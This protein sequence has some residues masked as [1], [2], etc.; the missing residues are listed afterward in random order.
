MGNKDI[1]KKDWL[2]TISTLLGAALFDQL[3]KIAEASYNFKFS[4]AFINIQLVFNKGLVGELC[5]KS[6]IYVC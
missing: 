3:T 5:L 6:K 1:S 2:L 4:S